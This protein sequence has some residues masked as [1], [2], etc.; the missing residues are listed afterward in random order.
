MLIHTNGYFFFDYRFASPT[1]SMSFVH[2]SLLGKPGLVDDD[3]EIEAMDD[4]SSDEEKGPLLS[5]DLDDD[6]GDE[7]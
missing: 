7:G 3:S 2:G 6:D 1:P 4:D 5:E